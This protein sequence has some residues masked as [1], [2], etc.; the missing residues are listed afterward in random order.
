M[1]AVGRESGRWQLVDD[2]RLSV[3]FAPLPVDVRLTNA[4]RIISRLNWCFFSGEGTRRWWT[5]F[6][7]STAAIHFGREEIR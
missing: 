6:R 1:I 2:S 4:T 3:F 7:F 5:V